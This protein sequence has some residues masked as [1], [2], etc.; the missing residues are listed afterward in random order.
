MEQ[1][2]CELYNINCIRFGDFK[3]K[4]KKN[5][6]VLIN[7]SKIISYPR[8]LESL[9]EILWNKINKCYNINLICSANI[10][11]IPLTTITSLKYN[12]S[13]AIIR[14]NLKKKNLEGEIPDNA[15]CILLDN[16]VNSGKTVEKYRNF[17]LKNNINISKI[18]VLYNHSQINLSDVIS[19]FDINIIINILYKH[20]KIDKL[21][22]DKVKTVFSQKPKIVKLPKRNSVIFNKL[23]N[24]IKTKQTNIGLSVELSNIDKILSL[25][26]N[27][28]SHICLLK[29]QI[30]IIKNVSIDFT[31]KLKKLSDKFNFLIL[32]SNAI[33]NDIKFL[34]FE[35]EK[36]GMD[37]WCDMFLID[38]NVSREF[39]SK[40]NYQ[41]KNL[42]IILKSNGDGDD[43][44]NLDQLSDVDYLGVMSRKHLNDN[45]G[46]YFS[47]LTKDIENIFNNG[48]DV[49]IIGKEIIE[50][51]DQEIE[52]IKYKNISWNFY[53][54]KNVKII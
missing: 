9:S 38:I 29:I 21:I 37:K 52:A 5:T 3:L 8:I 24:I 54:Y 7:L 42:G 25:I 40:F 50:S 26:N 18:I 28:G 22:Y 48:T 16:V 14:D 15:N 34:D 11:I 46:L 2:V 31:E 1:L 13:Q 39:L 27:V 23:L 51:K 53:K 19:I 47:Y 20:N 12:L 10:S 4:N 35:M 33:S 36:F 6:P 44:D 17:L 30:N 41:Y 45:N 43:Y 49:V 32:E